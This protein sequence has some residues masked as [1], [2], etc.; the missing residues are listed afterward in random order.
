MENPTAVCQLLLAEEKG[1]CGKPHE[2]F[3]DDSTEL[4]V[5]LPALLHVVWKITHLAL[6]TVKTNHQIRKR[7]VMPYASNK[8]IHANEI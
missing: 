2:G 4:V 5:C 6:K 8:L 1:P 3:T 7:G